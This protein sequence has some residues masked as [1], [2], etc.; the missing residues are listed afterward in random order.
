MLVASGYIAPG[1]SNVIEFITI[2][3][4]ASSTDFGDLTALEED[5]KDYQIQQ[6]E[7]SLEVRHQLL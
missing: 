1:S 7:Y 3:N 2:A 5:L 4:I 6:E